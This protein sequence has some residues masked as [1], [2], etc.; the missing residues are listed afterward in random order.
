MYV[1]LLGRS[2]RDKFWRS[3]QKVME[4]DTNIPTTDVHVSY[5]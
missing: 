3:R 2:V 1:N 4:D 5:I